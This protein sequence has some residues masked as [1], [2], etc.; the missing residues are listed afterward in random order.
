MPPSIHQVHVDLA[1]Y[2]TSHRI[3][4]GVRSRLMAHLVAVDDS[5]VPVTK[6][7]AIIPALACG[8]RNILKMLHLHYVSAFERVIGLPIGS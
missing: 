5:D 6:E 7:L 2:V 1:D 4:Q 3:I 8:H